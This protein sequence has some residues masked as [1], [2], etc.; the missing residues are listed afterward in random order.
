MPRGGPGI[1]EH[2]RSLGLERALYE[3]RVIVSS[4]QFSRQP[5]YHLRAPGQH[6]TLAHRAARLQ[7]MLDGLA[8]TKQLAK[9]IA[10]APSP[11]P[12]TSISR[13]HGM[14]TSEAWGRIGMILLVL[15]LSRH[16]C[17]VTRA[18]RCQALRILHLQMCNNM[19]QPGT[20]THICTCAISLIFCL[21]LSRP[22]RT[23]PDNLRQPEDSGFSL[24]VKTREV[25]NSRN[26]FIISR[27][28]L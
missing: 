10:F 25:Q 23:I 19:G 22:V 3:P 16:D 6:R 26:L 27:N 21:G 20:T 2:A 18:K 14:P 28:K 13:W 11:H 15:F 24:G 12:F 5:S 17:I 7:M 4:N 1:Y 8:A 9:W